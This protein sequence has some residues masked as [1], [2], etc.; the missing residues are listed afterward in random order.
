MLELKEIIWEITTECHNNCEYCGSCSVTDAAT[1][2]ED[3]LTIASNIATYPPES[4]NVSGGDPTLVPLA[5]HREIVD[6]FRAA[7]II[8]KIIGY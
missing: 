8:P 1:K 6:K 5:V 4:V 7:K 3:M 2:I